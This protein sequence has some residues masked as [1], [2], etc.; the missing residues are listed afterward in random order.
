MG[1]N[2]N[3]GLTVDDYQA[4]T[5]TLLENNTTDVDSDYFIVEAAKKKTFIVTYQLWEGDP[6]A[7]AS[8]EHVFELPYR[9]YIWIILRKICGRPDGYRGNR[10]RTLRFELK[11]A[12]TKPLFFVASFI[13]T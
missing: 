5:L 6:L 12:F 3:R 2:S 10:M 9:S 4:R 8:G 13:S 1:S 7:P 11:R